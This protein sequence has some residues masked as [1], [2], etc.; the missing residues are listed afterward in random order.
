MTSLPAYDISVVELR[1]ALSWVNPDLVLK[2]IQIDL[3][4]QLDLPP[5]LPHL[6]LPRRENQRKKRRP[7]RKKLKTILMYLVKMTRRKKKRQ[8]KAVQKCW[9]V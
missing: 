1:V 4:S 9:R 8:R 7:K 5:L 3:K 2:K 6:P